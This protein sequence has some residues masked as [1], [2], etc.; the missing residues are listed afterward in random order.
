[1]R[2]KHDSL[3]SFRAGAIVLFGWLWALTLSNF[4]LW[5]SLYQSD[6]QLSPGDLRLCDS[7]S[8]KHFSTSP[9]SL[10]DLEL[11]SNGRR[12]YATCIS[13]TLVIHGWKRPWNQLTTQSVKLLALC[14]HAQ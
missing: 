9:P 3:N 2:P 4:E 12:L 7:I 10:L 8:Q 6:S 5:T 14:R 11:C 13:Q 1:M